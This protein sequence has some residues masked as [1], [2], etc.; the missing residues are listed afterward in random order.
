LE[1]KN[2]LE[3]ELRRSNRS[4]GHP[5]TALNSHKGSAAMQLM[6]VKHGLR[7]FSLT[8]AKCVTSTRD[9]AT[10][11]ALLIQVMSSQSHFRFDHLDNTTWITTYTT[12]QLVQWRTTGWTAE[13]RS[14]TWDFIFSTVIRSVLG[15][16]QPFLCGKA[17]RACAD[18]SSPSGVEVELYLHS[19]IRLHGAVLN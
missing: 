3:R 1:N 4:A 8:E 12:A 10:F 2:S 9:W 6:A 16:I 14:P 18:H 11:V 17:A 5:R 13:V 19:I 7:V 15:P